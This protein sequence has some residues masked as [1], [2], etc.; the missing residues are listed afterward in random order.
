MLA[1]IIA[2]FNMSINNFG[3]P[4]LLI[5]GSTKFTVSNISLDHMA[6]GR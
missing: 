2:C 3:R 6:K 5:I 1:T 4:D